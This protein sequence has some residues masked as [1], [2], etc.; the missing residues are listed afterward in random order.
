MEIGNADHDQLPRKQKNTDSIPF[1]VTKVWF[2]TADVKPIT[3]GR[4][5]LNR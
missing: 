1:D 3:I 5:V 2:Q 4:M